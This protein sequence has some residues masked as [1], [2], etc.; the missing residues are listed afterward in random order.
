MVYQQEIRHL[1]KDSKS[2]HVSKIYVKRDRLKKV[3]N[4]DLEYRA[5]FVHV[6]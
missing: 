4:N 5:C 6:N 3:M 2:F 1:W